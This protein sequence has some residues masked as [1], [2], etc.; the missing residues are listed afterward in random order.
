MLGDFWKETL[1]I[2]LLDIILPS[3]C[4]VWYKT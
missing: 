3:R 2:M 1:E 4:R